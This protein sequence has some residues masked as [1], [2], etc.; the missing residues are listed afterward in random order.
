[1]VVEKRDGCYVVDIPG[2]D[3]VKLNR[4]GEMEE[5]VA[6]IRRDIGSAM[7]DGGVTK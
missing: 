2:V 4:V 3:R 1:M 5:E 7:G 6:K